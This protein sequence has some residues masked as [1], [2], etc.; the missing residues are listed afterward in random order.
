MDGNTLARELLA[1]PII[2]F[3]SDVSGRSLSIGRR[4]LAAVATIVRLAEL[5]GE[6]VTSPA[7]GHLFGGHSLRTGGAALLAGRGVHP[8]Q[9]QS[10]GRWK[11]PLVVHYAGDAMATG[12][13]EVL[14]RCDAA[15][16]APAPPAAQFLES[17]ERRLAGLEARELRPPH[18]LRLSISQHRA[19][20]AARCSRPGNP[21]CRV[22]IASSSAGREQQDVLW[23]VLRAEG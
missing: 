11:S 6:V 21:Q 4:S 18:C 12:I 5:S 14:H 9:I 20:A 3:R 13:A 15:R 17:I 8:L 1:R 10:M 2:R 19:T 23:L 22:W 16:S 7:G